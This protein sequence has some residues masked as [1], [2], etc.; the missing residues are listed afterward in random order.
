MRTLEVTTME[1]T[2]LSER[3]NKCRGGEISIPCSYWNEIIDDIVAL[4]NSEEEGWVWIDEVCKMLGCG[5]GGVF[6]IRERIDSL[7]NE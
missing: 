3:I 7:K 4:E 6:E 2:K 5:E 1:E